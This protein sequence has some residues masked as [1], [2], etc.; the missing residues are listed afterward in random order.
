MWLPKRLYES[1]P[2]L[3]IAIGAMFLAGTLYVGLD[4]WP[5]FGYLAVGALCVTLG[6]VVTAIR[7]K[8]RANEEARMP[9]SEQLFI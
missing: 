1:L 8:A 7:H 5:M 4:H 2:A 9:R 3:Y 6:V